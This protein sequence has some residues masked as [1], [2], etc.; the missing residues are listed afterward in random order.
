ME[1]RQK[2]MQALHDRATRREPL[3]ADEQQQLTAWYAEQDAL[4][5]ATLYYGAIPLEADI[6]ALEQHVQSLL[7]QII[8]SEKHIQTLN[9]QNA[10][11]RQELRE[12]KLRFARQFPL[13][14]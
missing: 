10:T 3:S 5:A 8:V 4:E 1:D 14:A 7:Q 9:T 11:L 12:L 6:V 13:A 2:A